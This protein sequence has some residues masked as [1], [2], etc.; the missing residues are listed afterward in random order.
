V[1]TR[2]PARGD[3]PPRRFRQSWASVIGRV[4]VGLP[5]GASAVHSGRLK[6]KMGA[7][8][9]GTRIRDVG[10]GAGDG[11]PTRER[12]SA[13][14]SWRY[15]LPGLSMA[16]VFVC[17]SLSPSLLPR[18]GVIQGLVSGITAAIGYGIGIV[19]A[20]AWRAFAD[21]DA[22]PARRRS[23]QV[24][25]VAAAV[26][27]VAAT[28]LSR[29]W[30]GRIRAL[31][32]VPPDGLASLVVVP[33]VAAFVFVV[34]IALSRALRRFYLWIAVRL[35]RWIGPRAARALG[36][37]VVVVGTALVVSGVVLDGLVA[38]ADQAFSVRN[39]STED[40]VAQP[41]AP[42]RSG[43][44]QSLVPWTSLGLQGRTFAGTGPSP[45]QI[46]AFTGATARVPV[47]AYAG[48]DSADTAEQRARL[49]V[50]DVARAGG[51]DRGT[52]VVMTTTGSG[53]V[54]PAAVESIEYLT[55]GDIA[56]VAMQYSYLPSW[57]SY[58]VDQQ[59]AR[60][61]GR[62]LFDAVYDR[63]SKLEA[64]HR[65]RLVVAGESL[66]SFG[67]ETAFS[68]EYD[69]RNRTGGAVFAGPPNFNTLYRE[70]VDGR[71]AGSLEVRPVYRDGRTVRFTDDPVSD[72]TPAALPWNGTRVLYL[73][74][75][76]D[77]I[78]WWSPRLILQRPDWLSEPR[79]D[80][81][82]SAMRWIPF[83]TFWQVSA[84]LPFATEVPDGHGHVY[85][86]EYVDAWA[87]VLQPPGWSED[88]AALLRRLVAPGA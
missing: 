62:E 48:L 59:R 49:A 43:S 44:P 52:L 80:D 35:R 38:A 23:W 36:W 61:A 9:R 12:R 26:A 79:G 54:D 21:R 77:P 17:L 53:W 67:G 20:W 81:V 56:T 22:G 42:E 34:L 87:H 41:A 10:V 14:R 24:F 30:Q 88:D 68:G 63:W 76:S 13:L 3:A 85:T 70:F 19:A 40:G 8:D 83:V 37:I 46:A 32:G 7:V 11:Q 18:S 6:D 47:R 74:H 84:D 73:Q 1:A 50:D 60:E 27:L 78:V 5:P 75:A 29:Y 2:P 15:S 69:L 31:M 65:P 28:V 86:R 64:D 82:V 45:E 71:D 16:L 25:A 58:L 66:G 4:R 72:M 39:A 55:G 51:F 57:I 33:I